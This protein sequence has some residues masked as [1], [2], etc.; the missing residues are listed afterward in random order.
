MAGRVGDYVQARVRAFA[1]NVNE[2]ANTIQQD[3]LVGATIELLNSGFGLLPNTPLGQK[4]AER[5]EQARK[6]LTGI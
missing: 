1:D 6:K 4:F 5:R 2:L 3:T